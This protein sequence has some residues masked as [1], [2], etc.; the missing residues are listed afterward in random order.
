MHQTTG[1]WTGSFVAEKLRKLGEVDNVKLLAPQVLHI[2]RIQNPPF[3]AGTVASDRVV[4]STIE[5]LLDSKFGLSFIANVP[6]EA[7]WTGAAIE[8]ASSQSV[9]VGG[10][11]DLLSAISLRDVSQYVKKEFALVARILRQ[12]SR[13]QEFDR[14]YDRLYVIKRRRLSGV[15]L[16]LLNEYALT[17]DHVRIARDRYGEFSDVLI[18][19]PNGNAT[20]SAQQA[21]ASMGAQIHDLSGLML[22]L[23]RP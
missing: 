16:V 12:H 11:G 13:V 6:K 19:N 2:T 10:F 17:A 8:L 15:T 18:T 22:R 21:A 5:P 23:N 14:V 3:V 1:E 7:I 20:S 4:R 9:A